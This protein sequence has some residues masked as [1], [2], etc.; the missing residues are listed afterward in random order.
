MKCSRCGTEAYATPSAV[1]QHH[2]RDHAAELAAERQQRQATLDASSAI[3]IDPAPLGARRRLLGVSQTRLASLLGI[4]RSCLSHYE[5]G[6]RPIPVVVL[7]AAARVLG[8][9]VWMLLS[10]V[11]HGQDRP[12]R[13]ETD[14]VAP[15]TTP[16][17]RNA[18]T[19]D[20]QE[21]DHRK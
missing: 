7:F 6:T 18:A 16:R 15:A 3:S 2:R 10:V 19:T 21:G 8:T 17:R 12:G 1:G 20:D 14:R 4:Q 5:R 9:P 11:E 13:P